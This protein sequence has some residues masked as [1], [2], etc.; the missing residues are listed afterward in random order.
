MSLPTTDLNDMCPMNNLLLLMKNLD[1]F[2]MYSLSMILQ[3]MTDWLSIHKSR[4]TDTPQVYTGAKSSSPYSIRVA[5][6][7]FSLFWFQILSCIIMG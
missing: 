7:L 5:G 3:P 2:L 1:V 4:E 6:Q